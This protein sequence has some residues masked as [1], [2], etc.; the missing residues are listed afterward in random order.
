MKEIKEENNNKKYE[1]EIFTWLQLCMR[2]IS[3]GGPPVHRF[4][5]HY[6]VFNNKHSKLEKNGITEQKLTK[7]EKKNKN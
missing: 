4:I 3:V 6:F 5:C 7:T 1:N 2:E